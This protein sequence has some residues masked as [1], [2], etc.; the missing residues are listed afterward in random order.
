MVDQRDHLGFCHQGPQDSL[1]SVYWQYYIP[2]MVAVMCSRA[3]ATFAAP[4]TQGRRQSHAKREGRRWG[5]MNGAHWEDGAAAR[6]T[7]STW[8]FGCVRE[9]QSCESA[10]PPPPGLTPAPARRMTPPQ[11]PRRAAFEPPCRHPLAG[12]RAR[13]AAV[14]AR[15]TGCERS[16]LCCWVARACACEWSGARARILLLT[17]G[18]GVDDGAHR[19]PRDTKRIVACAQAPSSHR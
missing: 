17:S 6:R 8:P 13:G 3:S 19:E 10:S 9:A 18:G 14:A 4:G 7:C 12:L 16:A 1:F 11:P 2:Q 15:E 5:N